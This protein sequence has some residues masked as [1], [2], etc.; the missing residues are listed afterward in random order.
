LLLGHITGK[1]ELSVC[2]LQHQEWIM[3]RS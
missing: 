2:R 3:C 1:S